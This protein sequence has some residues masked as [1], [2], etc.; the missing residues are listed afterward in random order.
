RLAKQ[1]KKLGW[2][3]R[4]PRV[5][6]EVGGGLGY[7][8]R[9]LGGGLSHEERRGARYVFVDI[10]RPFLKTQLAMGQEGGWVAAGLQANAEQLPLRDA[11]VALAVDNDNVADWT[12]GELTR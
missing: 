3:D 1:L 9:D 2:C 12:A 6:L 5:I 10:T 11:H 7:V 4:K 8:A